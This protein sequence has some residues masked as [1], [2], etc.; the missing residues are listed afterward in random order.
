MIKKYKLVSC[1]LALLLL[2]NVVISPKSVEAQM[3]NEATATQV[4]V[5]TIRVVENGLVSYLTRINENEI[6]LVSE[7]KT[8]K[9]TSN[10]E[11]NL[12]I[13]GVYDSSVNY[14]EPSIRDITLSMNAEGVTT[15][16][17]TWRTVGTLYWNNVARDKTLS[18]VLGL[19]LI[20]LNI[21]KS[22]S[23]LIA[24][25]TFGYNHYSK[26]EVLYY[27]NEVQ[28]RSDGITTYRRYL[29]IWRHYYRSVL[30]TSAY[31]YDYYIWD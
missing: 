21:P 27:T 12:Y 11:G 19:A 24:T 3:I 1:F 26:T 30:L 16:E 22:A 14:L 10:I 5:D 6:E 31:D 8:H 17:Y 15:N 7:G 25:I 28:Q 4:D 29:S 20:A 9:I 23:V 2:I 18:Y 13:D